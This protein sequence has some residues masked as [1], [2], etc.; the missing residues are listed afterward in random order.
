MEDEKKPKPQRQGGLIASQE[1]IQWLR[2]LDLKTREGVPEFSMSRL[3]ALGF[4]EI[5]DGQPAI[6]E[7]GRRLL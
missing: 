2:L 1:D 7:K 3:I 5:R 4:V 6:T